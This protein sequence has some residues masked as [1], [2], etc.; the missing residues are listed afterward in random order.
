M[1]FLGIIFYVSIRSVILYCTSVLRD[2][3]VTH[4]FKKLI[5]EIFGHNIKCSLNYVC[6]NQMTCL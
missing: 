5:A 4:V 3:P 2:Y 6:L 1:M